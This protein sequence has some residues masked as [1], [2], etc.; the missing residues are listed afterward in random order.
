VHFNCQ[1]SSAPAAP[2]A[3]PKETPEPYGC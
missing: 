3:D 2:T 1:K